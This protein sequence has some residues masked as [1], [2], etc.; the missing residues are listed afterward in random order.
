MTGLN[1]QNEEFVECLVCHKPLGYDSKMHGYMLCHEHLKC[2]DC[3]DEVNVVEAEWC[4]KKYK[5]ECKECDAENIPYHEFKV[6]HTRCYALRYKPTQT[7]T[8]EELDKLNLCRLMIEPDLERDFTSNEN[9]AFRQS[10]RYVADMNFEQKCRHEAK[11]QACLAQVQIAIR[12]DPHYKKESLAEREKTRYNNARKEALTSSRPASKTPDDATEIQIGQ[13]M[14]IHGL[15]E[16]S[17]AKKIM[18]DRNKAIKGLVAIG[19]PEPMARENINA[20][21]LKKGILKK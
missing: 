17:V 15:T 12:K 10:E 5:Q 20:D 16:R 19:I 7:V 14:E 13:F 6:Y 9:E 4:L 21:L 18:A 8:Q 2:E 1:G 3:G 11:L